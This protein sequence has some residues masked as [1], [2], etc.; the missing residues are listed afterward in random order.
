MFCPSEQ[1][2]RVIVFL[3]RYGRIPPADLN[4]F[5][6]PQVC[7]L[8]NMVNEFLANER[9]AMEKQSKA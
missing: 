9:K 2:A 1:L 4:D 7:N 5:S 3:S 6:L 8:F